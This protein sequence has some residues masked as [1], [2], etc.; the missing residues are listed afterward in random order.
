MTQ[1][2]TDYTDILSIYNTFI[3]V[4]VFLRL[5]SLLVTRRNRKKEP[6]TDK[7]PAREEDRRFI[8]KSRDTGLEHKG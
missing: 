3:K 5:P 4:N 6:V 2:S 1:S 7:Q 8:R